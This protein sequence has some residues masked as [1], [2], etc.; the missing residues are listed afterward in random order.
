[1]S[2]C[3]C[4]INWP[5]IVPV[6]EMANRY[7]LAV[8]ATPIPPLSVQ[9]VS[10]L[11]WGLAVDGKSGYGPSKDVLDQ[12]CDFRKHAEEYEWRSDLWYNN[13]HPE[14]IAVP[15]PLDFSVHDRLMERIN[16][17][18]EMERLKVIALFEDLRNISFNVFD[19]TPEIIYTLLEQMRSKAS[20][21]T[22]SD[23]N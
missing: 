13:T 7:R 21:S 6:G 10:I 15:C 11:F 17:W 23:R 4:T 5:N 22:K 16:E 18:T 9:E 3:N 14:G 19:L 12:W 20:Q 8:R 2:C 1:M